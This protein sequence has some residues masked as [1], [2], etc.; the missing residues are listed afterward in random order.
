MQIP[1][2]SALRIPASPPIIAVE[3]TE[4]W[5]AILLGETVKRAP[6]GFSV[7]PRANRGSSI[8]HDD[9]SR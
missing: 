1:R 8:N 2:R 9:S 3:A 4:E 6:D 7:G 5:L